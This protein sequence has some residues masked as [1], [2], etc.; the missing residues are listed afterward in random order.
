MKIGVYKCPDFP[1]ALQPISY[2]CNGWDK[3]NAN[4]QTQPAFKVTKFKRS[5][6][7]VFV[8][9]AHENRQVDN[10][11]YHDVWHVEHLPTAPNQAGRRILDDN[12]HRGLVNLVFLDGHVTAKAYKTVV[13]D[14]F[15]LIK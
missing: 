5:A 2:V 7:V 8:T 11:V 12:R 10:F 3:L 6:E 15:R 9:E 14:D 13:A 4:G 1:N